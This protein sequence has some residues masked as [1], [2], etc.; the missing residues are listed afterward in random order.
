MAA[1]VLQGTHGGFSP[2]SV[3]LSPAPFADYAPTDY[4]SLADGSP[5]LT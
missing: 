2:G 1:E 3:D 5:F 4:G